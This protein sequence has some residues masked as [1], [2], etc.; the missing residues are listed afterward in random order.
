MVLY[1]NL[2]EGTG[3]T[4]NDSSGN[5]NNGALNFYGDPPTVSS[6]WT[7]SGQVNGAIINDGNDDFINVLDSTSLPDSAPLTVALWIKPNSLDDFRYPIAKSN[8]GSSWAFGVDDGSRC[9]TSGSV[10][11]FA[12]TQVCATSLP[13]TIGNWYHIAFTNDGAQTKIYINGLL[14]HTEAQLIPSSS[15]QPVVI[16]KKGDGRNFN[17]FIDEVKIYNTVRSDGE[18]AVDAGVTPLTTPTQTPTPIDTPTPTPSETP[19]PSPTGSQVLINEFVAHVGSTFPQEWVEFYNPGSI[20]LS[21]FYID[22]DTN[23]DSDAGS[24]DKIP[25]TSLN[26]SNPL[27][28]FQ[29]LGTGFLNDG[30]DFVVLFAGDGTLI[31]QHQYLSDPGEDTA[32]GREPDGGSWKTCG[33]PSQGNTNTGVC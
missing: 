23:F 13:L 27:Y 26:T 6:G 17:G 14:Q 25:L 4:A 16:G 11:M 9:G 24:S 29:L 33:V 22:D 18:I 5:G 28:P 15:G 10:F 19:T 20:D 7:G 3:T 1:L 32:I 8:I 12:N 21:S 30:G 31:D 2:D